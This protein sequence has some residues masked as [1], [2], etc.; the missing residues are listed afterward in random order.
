MNAASAWK[1]YCSN[2]NRGV[3]WKRYQS[4]GKGYSYGAGVKYE[5]V[6]GI[7]LSVEKQYSSNHTL[8]YH[9]RGAK[10]KKL[11]GNNDYPSRAGKMVERRR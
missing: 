3:V 2:V 5:E 6:I 9:V 11:C 8:Y 1:E 7:D 4:K 10:K